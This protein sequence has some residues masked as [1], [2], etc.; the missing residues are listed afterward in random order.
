[1][2]LTVSVYRNADSNTDCTNGGLSSKVTSLTIVNVDGPF[3]PSERSPAV[4]LVEGP[5]N[6]ARLV[7]ADLH[8]ANEW[9]MYGGNIGVTSDSRLGEAVAKITGKKFD[10]GIVKIFDRV[11]S[12]EQ[13]R[14]LSI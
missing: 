8:E 13:M 5:Y 2:G 11:E 12:A 7:P 14:R 10:D 6:T 3:D 4:V 1:M 9:V